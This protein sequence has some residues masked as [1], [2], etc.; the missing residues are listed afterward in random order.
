MLRMNSYIPLSK[1]SKQKI[2]L[3]KKRNHLLLKL[4][5]GGSGKTNADRKNDGLKREEKVIIFV[6]CRKHFF[7][8]IVIFLN[9]FPDVFGK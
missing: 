5:K 2:N 4:N 6:L 1:N 7:L 9:I 3:S 8:P